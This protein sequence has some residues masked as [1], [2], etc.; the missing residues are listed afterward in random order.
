MGVQGE[1]TGRVW[2]AARARG[3]CRGI[4][5]RRAHPAFARGHRGSRAKRCG[6]RTTEQPPAQRERR[7]TTDKGPQ[8]IVRQHVRQ[9]PRGLSHVKSETK[10]MYE[11]TED[12]GWLS[13]ET[14]AAEGTRKHTLASRVVVGVRSTAHGHSW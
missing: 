4:L 11:V 7:P 2:A 8:G 5:E 3:T 9:T 12:S 14:G 10:Q 1:E 13:V 6:T